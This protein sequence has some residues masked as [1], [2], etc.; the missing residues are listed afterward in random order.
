M[1]QKKYVKMIGDKVTAW[2]LDSPAADG[3]MTSTNVTLNL[4]VSAISCNICGY[5]TSNDCTLV[6]FG[7]K[8]CATVDAIDLSVLPS[9]SRAYALRCG[10]FTG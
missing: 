1:L 3:S 10:S 9:R 8:H 7:F 2:P 4:C 6:G 5:A